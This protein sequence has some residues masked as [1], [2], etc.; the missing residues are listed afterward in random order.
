MGDTT[1]RRRRALPSAPTTPRGSVSNAPPSPQM[2]AFSLEIGTRTPSSL[3]GPVVPVVPIVPPSPMHTGM[4]SSFATPVTNPPLSDDQVT[5]LDRSPDRAADADM[6]HQNVIVA[7]RVRPANGREI[8]FG[9][10][11]I[12]EMEDNNTTI[13]G[14]DKDHNFRYDHSFWSNDKS[15]PNFA[16]QEQVFDNMGLP[17]LKRSLEGYNCCLFA[18]G[19]TGSGKSYTMMGESHERGVIP[20]FSQRM[21]EL[22]DSKP[23][24]EYKVEISYFEIYA[25]RI[26][27][28]LVPPSKGQKTKNHLKVREH[29]VMGP[30]VENL[31]VYPALNYNDIEGYMT[32]GGKYRAT[33]STNMNATSSRS[34]AVFTIHIT[35]TL[36]EEGEEHTKVSKVNLIDLAGSERSDSAGTTGQRLREGSAINKSLHT[37]GKII[38]LLAEKG[39]TSRRRKI[40]VP[41]RD[42]V[43]TWILKDS[44]GGNSKTG[45][46]A[47]L[48]PCEEN[49]AETLSTLRYA[50]QARSIV[51]EAKI[52]EDPNIALIRQ[53]R[54]EIDNYRS[55]YGDIK[56]QHVPMAEVDA[57]RERLA[58]S[59]RL[60]SDINRSWEDKLR[61]SEQVRDQNLKMM[62]QQGVTQDLRK[63]NNRLPNLVNLNEDPQLSEMLIYI[64]KEGVTT[65][66]K[67]A[68]NDIELSGV[69]VRAKHAAIHCS[70]DN[71]VTLTTIEDALLYVNGEIQPDNSSRQLKHGDRVVIGNHHFFRLNIPSTVQKANSAGEGFDGEVKDYR[72]AREE[73]ERIQAAKIEAQLA[74]AHQK[75]TEEIL[76]QLEAEKMIAQEKLNQQRLEYEHKIK[77]IE[78]IAQSGNF[79]KQ[80]NLERALA[81]AEQQEAALAEIEAQRNVLASEKKD[82]EARL[83]EEKEQARKEM[84]E[85]A[86]AKNKII[87]D[88]ELEKRKIEEDLKTLKEEHEKRRQVGSSTG[89]M[90]GVGFIR[91]TVT[92]PHATKKSNWMHISGLIAEA[93]EISTRLGQNTVFRRSD[94]YMEDD[95]PQ[96]KLHNTKVG[97][98]T[99]WDL[100]K[101]EDR[102][103]QIKE[104]Y[105]V[106]DESGGEDTSMADELFYD[107][108]DEWHHEVLPGTPGGPGGVARAAWLSAPR[109]QSMI[110]I[111]GHGHRGGV[112]GGAPLSVHGDQFGG[113]LSAIKAEARAKRE[114]TSTMDRLTG[115][116][117]AANGRRTS[118]SARARRRSSTN[119]A[120][121][122]LL[123][124]QYIKNSLNSL[125]SYSNKPRSRADDIV[126]CASA[127]LTAVDAL[128]HGFTESVGGGTSPVTTMATTALVEHG[129]IRNASLSAAISMELLCSTVRAL[130]HSPE[131]K[132]IGHICDTLTAV[133]TTTANTLAKLLQGIENG[134]G[135]MVTEARS[136]VLNDIKMLSEA[137]GELAIATAKEGEEGDDAESGDEHAEMGDEDPD[138]FALEEEEASFASSSRMVVL[139]SSGADGNDPDAI[140]PG[141]V[142]FKIDD[143][144]LAAFDRG[145]RNHVHNSLAKLTNDM[146]EC[147]V[148]VLDSVQ[149]LGPASNVGASV[150]HAASSVVKSTR[151]TFECAQRLQE[152]LSA[153][154]SVS[155]SKK[156]FYRKSFA[157]AKGIINEVRDVADAVNNLA[158]SCSSSVSGGDDVESVMSH[159]KNLRAAIARLTHSAEAKLGRNSTRA[160]QLN[161]ALRN[162][163]NDVTR[164]SKQLTAE[165]EDFSGSEI[166]RAR[167]KSS[168]SR[169][170]ISSPMTPRSPRSMQRSFRKLTGTPTNEV[171]R[172]TM[173]VEHQSE[174]YRLEAE[175]ADAQK[176]VK[177]LHRN[178][179]GADSEATSTI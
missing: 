120:S 118:Q 129:T 53:L 60:M 85:E 98:S 165:C 166:G 17:L 89:G 78:T 124:R 21:W 92:H 146:D 20:R 47:T 28:L 77:E 109:A 175:L 172:R 82:M 144:I 35:Q 159:A 107:P 149:R 177:D 134:I 46:L 44:L 76:E 91:G 33:A 72:F 90:S 4:A 79:D 38:S 179:Y 173:L 162:A 64:I 57:L 145:T 23:E 55:Q 114:S 115:A 74:E 174:V 148:G 130:S 104:A 88:L 128:Y 49:Y 116:G 50:H 161:A 139:G 112:L 169:R 6:E 54:A 147:A 15:S 37:L 168:M 16:G 154:E 14:P 170:S 138:E 65:V 176:T 27:D 143:E 31:K 136:D 160:N 142:D 106:I 24:I 125:Q 164:A 62:E 178:L 155:R 12:I 68:D 25:E 158:M 36:E 41:Y 99:T 127:L 167:R 32:L 122:P 121:V 137:A 45:M 153:T 51:N 135:T 150:V 108:D 40:F 94:N 86:A 56:G 101:F 100:A 30:Y 119:D 43:L 93:N 18:Y 29:P 87:G 163:C 105:R 171:Q 156:V 83:L 132:Y 73:M 42:S 133:A 22:I 61:Q 59:E 19:Q 123:C 111:G 110:D 7:V 102:L 11:C 75:K 140:P 10:G 81:V 34:H 63:I 3:R 48:S 71:V 126:E 103:A 151:D 66:G 141:V 70:E 1:P 152:E 9:G 39:Q 117:G 5:P 69:F 2:A 8:A 113:I 97:I 52:N 131:G 96:I 13:H 67:D 26:F 95:E 80:Q 157:W 58:M 84:E